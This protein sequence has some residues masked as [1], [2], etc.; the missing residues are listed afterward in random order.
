MYFRGCRITTI[1]A[2]RKRR[3]L[4]QIPSKV[5]GIIGSPPKTGV[6]G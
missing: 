4:N 6:T 5:E 2:R 1:A 3:E